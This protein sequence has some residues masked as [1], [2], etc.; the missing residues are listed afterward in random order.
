[1]TKS[2]PAKLEREIAEAIAPACTTCGRSAASPYRRSVG[3]K[4]VEGCIDDAHTGHLYGDSLRWHMRPEAKAFR[5]SMKSRLRELLKPMTRSRA[6]MGKGEYTKLA[7]ATSV[8][9]IEKYVND[10]AFSTNY[11]VDPD[12]LT[13]T[14]PLKAPP[15]S[16]FVMRHRGGY[17][18]GRKH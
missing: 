14:N 8:P 1:M 12:T 16:W 2:S 4:I 17:L 6:H 11:R 15:A 13:I 18:F 5:A 3:G 9:R 10:Y 7:T